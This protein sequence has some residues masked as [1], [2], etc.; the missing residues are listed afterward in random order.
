MAQPLLTL[1]DVAARIA[2]DT[3]FD[4][5]SFSIFSGDRHCLVG[6]N[7]CGK[8]TLF[9]L[10]IGE[11]EPDAGERFVQQGVHIGYLPQRMD[12]KTG[13]SVYEYVQGNL[14]AEEQGEYQLYR[15]DQVLEPLDV[16]GHLLMDNLSGGQKRRAA[17]ARALIGNPDILL[18][19]EPTNHL[20]ISAIGWLEE[21]LRN[22]RGGVVIISHD[23]IFLENT[24]NRT[25]WIHQGS[26]R[27]NGKGY[28]DFDAWSERVMEEE[29]ARVQKLGRKLAEEEHWRERGVTARRKR[30]M[31][32]MGELKT[33]REKLRRDRSSLVQASGSVQ[34]PPLKESDA[35][36]LVAELDNVSKSYNGRQIINGFTTR[37]LRGDK[38]GIIG[39]NGAGKSTLLKIM[40]GELEADTGTVKRGPTLRLAYFDQN[41]DQLDPRKTL[42]QTLCP[43]G[44]DT[45][46]VGGNPKHVIAYLKD[47]LFDAKQAQTPTSALSGGEANRLLLAKILAQPSDVLVL[48]EPT[49][50]LDMDTLDMLQ[51]MIADYAGTVILVSHDRD[52]LD[53]TVT[54]TIACEGNGVMMEYVGG[55]QDYVAQSREWHKKREEEASRRVNKTAPTQPAV[56][57]QQ[58]P[59]AQTKLSYKQQRALDLLPARIA[60]LETRIVQLEA[61]LSDTNL[62]A[63][64][65][66]RFMIA[67]REVETAQQQLAAAEEE[68]LEIAMLAEEIKN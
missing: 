66:E 49:N 45:V 4:N 59:K 38:I 58:K 56:A 42:W 51:E 32:R 16:S 63:K 9:R 36:K 61:E 44:G 7:G 39:K 19:D 22:F 64:Q 2:G 57:E 40:A 15:I 67:T 1:R 68:W 37:V 53:R 13:Q 30:N 52:F 34:L 35:S 23:R 31:R 6:R 62:Y 47:F 10:M 55:Y 54:R 48:D 28:S 8:S 24:S 20:D 18:L 50:D 25:L 11:R 27:V 21:Y 65:P 17:L 43:D 41:R 5:V 33:L 26:M 46:F 3:L 29:E 14:P 60:E 12:D